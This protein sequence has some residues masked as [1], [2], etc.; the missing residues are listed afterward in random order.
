VDDRTTQRLKWRSRRGLLE[1]DLIF[2]RFWNSSPP[3]TDADA[4]ALD[5]L[6]MLPDNDMLD[7]LLGRADVDADSLT[8]PLLRR[9]RQI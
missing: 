2:A 7:L 9:L 5:R 8:A 1:L 3:L 4:R 6:L